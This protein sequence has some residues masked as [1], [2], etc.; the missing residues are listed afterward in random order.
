[1]YGEQPPS[2][3]VN[4]LSMPTLFD[5]LALRGVTLPNR[6]AVSPMCQYSCQDGYAT[7]W[8]LVHLGSRA[9]GGAGLI[10]A[11][12]TAVVPEGRISPQDLGIWS[13]EHA[14]RLEPVARFVAAEGAVPGIQLAHAGRKASTWRP[15]APSHGMVAPEQGGWQ[16][17]GPSAVAFADNYPVPAALDQAGIDA[18]I[19]AFGVAARRAVAV[20]FR[21]IEIH[22]A[23]GY[24]LHEF[25][26]PHSNLRTDQWGGSFENRTRLLLAVV[27]RI[28]TVVPDRTPLVV[29]ISATDWTPEGWSVEE[30]VELVRIL[31]ARGVDL[32]DCST[33][34]NVSGVR[35]ELK[36]G[37]QVPF[38]E[39]IRCETGVPTGAVGLITEAA[40]ADQIV[41][42]GQADLV[43]LAR[44][45]LRDP[46]WPLHAA[47]ALGAT[48]SWPAQ[49]LRA[50]PAGTPAR[51][52]LAPQDGAAVPG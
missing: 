44:E 46:Y 30:S 6:I 3:T 24:L 48:V 18:V 42:S 47:R 12:A 29:R 1:M 9:S 39:R 43:L 20:G 49:Y 11:E 41:R 38:A 35:I 34:G 21:L 22:A 8:H 33:G 7:D 5:S 2:G 28:R 37:Y 10:I 19:D 27:D 14:A 23:H 36:P 15:W 52:P 45:L 51:E 32:V 16:T 40:Q 13:D 26:S 4:F 17:V 50:A 25:L 31:G